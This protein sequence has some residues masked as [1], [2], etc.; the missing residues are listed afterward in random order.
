M[1][2]RLNQ[3]FAID[4]S[5]KFVSGNN[6][7]VKCAIDTGSATAEV[8][9]L[10]AHVTHF[11]K[12]GSPP[13]LYLSPR[14]FFAEGKAIRGGVPV[15]FPWFGP[16][17]DDPKAPM[18][19]FVR[20]SLWDVRKT[21][22]VEGGVSIEFGFESNG[23]FK[24]LWPHEVSVVMTVT[25]TNQLRIELS[26]TNRSDQPIEI[27]EAL[28]SYFPV[29]DVR[30]VSV[31]G[32]AGLDYFNK[33]V[34]VNARQ[35]DPR[36]RFTGEVDRVYHRA[37]SVQTIVDPGWKRKIIVEKIGSASTV[38]WNP[39]AVKAAAMADLG[40][41]QW[42]HFCCVETANAMPNPVK[43]APGASHRIETIHRE[44]AV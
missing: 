31:E 10:G 3:N 22:R 11:Q 14:S 29:S 24:N 36:V 9:L 19:G 38:V 33:A 41:D 16:K 37:P 21:A 5:L 15:C 35:D 32:L 34:G 25:V 6:G 30:N 4:S 43:L 27:T 17:A 44:E 1:L 18:H 20:T 12:K 39:N 7:L 23:R 2:D 26:S 28:H 42:P 8:Y 13:M 40:E